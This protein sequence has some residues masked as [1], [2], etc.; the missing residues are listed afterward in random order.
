MPLTLSPVEI[1]LVVL[2]F[3]VG[4]YSTFELFRVLR[5]NLPD[6]PVI[7]Q[8]LVFITAAF[9]NGLVVFEQATPDTLFCAASICRAVQIL[10]G[11]LDRIVDL[12]VALDVLAF[13]GFL[14]F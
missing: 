11:G 4:S 5:S 12:R 9:G 10:I 7:Y 1:S 3:L 14:I 6:A 8:Y 13:I 2:N